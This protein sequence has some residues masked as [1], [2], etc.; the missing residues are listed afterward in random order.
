ML[1]AY[2]RCVEKHLGMSRSLKDRPSAPRQYLDALAEA[3]SADSRS[4]TGRSPGQGG[5]LR[6]RL[7][8]MPIDFTQTY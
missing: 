4:F 5:S 7:R 8:D 2:P 6:R 1:H 3:K